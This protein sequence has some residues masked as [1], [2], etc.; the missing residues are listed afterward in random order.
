MGVLDL[1]N[2]GKA[3]LKLSMAGLDPLER[4]VSQ[5]MSFVPI[6]RASRLSQIATNDRPNL[7][8]FVIGHGDEHGMYCSEATSFGEQQRIPESWIDMSGVRPCL[9]T[10]VC[11]SA[12]YLRSSGLCERLTSALAFETRIAI[13]VDDDDPWTSR[14]WCRFLRGLVR[15]VERHCERDWDTVVKKRVE[16]WYSRFRGRRPRRLWGRARATDEWMLH[17]MRMCLLRQAKSLVFLP[18]VEEGK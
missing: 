11:R 2:W 1:S 7:A 3:R 16:E 18:G 14:Y 6:T 10:Y 5:K 8:V 13:V 15:L 17:L 12:Q 9:F 4:F